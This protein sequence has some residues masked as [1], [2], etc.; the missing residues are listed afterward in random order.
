MSIIGQGVI[1]GSF[2]TGIQKGI[3]INSWSPALTNKPQSVSVV[4][5]FLYDSMFYNRSGTVGYWNEMTTFTHFDDWNLSQT[6]I[7][8][9]CFGYCAYC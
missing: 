5:T 2:N 9:Y 6:N 4:N 7:P 1:L 8:T 3:Q